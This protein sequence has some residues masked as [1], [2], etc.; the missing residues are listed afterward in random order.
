M[1]WN[2]CT[3]PT[4]ALTPST[5]SY[6]ENLSSCPQ[7]PEVPMSSARWWRWRTELH[8]TAGSHPGFTSV[9]LFSLGRKG[10]FP[11]SKEA[12]K[13]A[14]SALLWK[15][16]VWSRSQPFGLKENQPQCQQGWRQELH[17]SSIPSCDPVHRAQRGPWLP[18]KS[19]GIGMLGW[20]AA[21]NIC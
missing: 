11:I 14:L 18:K 2:N 8:S 17:C 4:P 10:V 7:L 13:L 16:H 12:S 15:L 1:G 3:Q 9:P 20:Y 5:L 21:L 19:G 6:I